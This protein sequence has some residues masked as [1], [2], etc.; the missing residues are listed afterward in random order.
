MERIE[1]LKEIE[2]QAYRSVFEDGI[3]DILWGAI[4]LIGAAV[5][6][7][8]T[9]GLSRY[10]GYLAL[11]VLPLIPWIGKRLITIPRLGSVEFSPKRKS[12]G[13][14]LLLVCLVIILLQLPLFIMG[15]GRSLFDGSQWSYI[16]LMAAPA[17]AVAVVFVS[18][19]RWY[20][21]LALMLFAIL[22]SELLMASMTRPLASALSFG[23]PGILIVAYGCAL[24]V[25]FIRKYPK[26]Q[27]EVAHVSR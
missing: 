9:I 12:R 15:L 23:V 8:E 24:L 6:A 3:Y 1:S 10:Y 16:V 7:L 26:S 13:W 5:S 2:R 17:V 11:I 22:E 25:K 27:S 14:L 21:Y 19:P 18:F 20:I 4:F